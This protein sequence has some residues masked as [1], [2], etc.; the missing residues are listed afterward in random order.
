MHKENNTQACFN[1]AR[2]AIYIWFEEC[3]RP[4]KNERNVTLQLG[5]RF[6]V[7]MES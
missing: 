2:L 7:M 1:T 3:L 5:D 4:E 6:A